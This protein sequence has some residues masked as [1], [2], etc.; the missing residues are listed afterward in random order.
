M[1]EYVVLPRKMGVAVKFLFS[2]GSCQVSQ[3]T[4]QKEVYFI[5]QFITT[6]SPK[7]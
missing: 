5:W 4:L 2:N 7:K 6:A 3:N 1:A